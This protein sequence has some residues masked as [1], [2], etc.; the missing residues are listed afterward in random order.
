MGREPSATVMDTPRRRVLAAAA[1]GSTLGL[2][3][4]GGLDGS[5]GDAPGQADDGTDSAGDGSDAQGDRASA[6]VALDVRSE[7]QAAREDIETRVEDGNLSQD[8]ARAELLDAQAEIVSAAVDDLESYAAGVDGLSVEDANE[9]A[10]AALVTGP[11]TGVLGALETEPVSAL[12]SAADFP[13]PQDGD[14]PNGS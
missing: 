11:A 13:A 2:A 3:G 14:Q 9:R 4:C 10:G 7:I 12:L 5:D 1:T 6:T 8:E